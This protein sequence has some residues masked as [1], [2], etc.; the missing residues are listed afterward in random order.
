MSKSD[1]VIGFPNSDYAGAEGK[2]TTQ[3]GGKGD[4][5]DSGGDITTDDAAV[6]LFTV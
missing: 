2:I 1:D 6:L 3:A 5:R 4:A